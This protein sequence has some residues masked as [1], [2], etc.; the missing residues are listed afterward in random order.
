MNIEQIKSILSGTEETLR[1]LQNQPEYQVIENSEKFATPND[2]VLADAVQ[3]LS[4]IYQAI[5]E[6]EYYFPDSNPEEAPE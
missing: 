5:V 2:L 1:L 3:T 6:S 4:E